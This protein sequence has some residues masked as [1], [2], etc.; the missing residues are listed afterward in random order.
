M[1]ISGFSVAVP[2]Q[3]AAVIAQTKQAGTHAA[4]TGIDGSME[5]GIAGVLIFIAYTSTTDAAASN[6]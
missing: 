3:N 4:I 1:S 2:G 5:L 6:K